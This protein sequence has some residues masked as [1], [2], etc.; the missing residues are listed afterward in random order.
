MSGPLPAHAEVLAGPDVW[1]EGA[2]VDQLAR[3]ACAD[4]CVRAVGLPDLHP[5]PGTPIGASFAFRGIVWP[6]LVGGDAG[7]GVR[8]VGIPRIKAQGDALE[9]RVRNELDT[10]PLDEVDPGALLAAVWARGARG[11]CEVAGV[12][13]EL[14]A[15]AAREEAQ[16]GPV[17]PVPDAVFGTQLGSVGGGNHFLELSRV[18]RVVDRDQAAAA[19]LRRGGFA[20]VAH[21]GSRGLGKH[22]ASRWGG[23]ALPEDAAEAWLQDLRGTVNFARANRLI[24]CWRMLR[25]VGAAHPGRTGGSLELVHNVVERVNLPDGP[26]W[27]HRKGAAP[28]AAGQLTVVLGSRGAESWVMLGQ[29]SARSLESVAHG[30]GR[31]M[32]RGQSIEL[33]R[34]RH[35]RASLRRTATGGRVICDDRDALY[36]EHPDCYKPIEPVIATLEAAGTAARVASLLPLITV[37]R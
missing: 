16:I 7:C 3:V 19:G 35:T 37:K 29:G 12:P 34:H 17:G 6:S 24:L 25:A 21:S 8:L 32:N 20:V 4:G 2:A 11:L 27:V 18:R 26:A 9:R 31:R 1:L 30:A 5:G 14:A 23:G 15:F 36:A 22:I 28:A 33:M 10:D 13:D